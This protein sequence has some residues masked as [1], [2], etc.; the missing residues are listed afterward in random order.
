MHKNR[1]LLA[2]D[3][4]FQKVLYCRGILNVHFLHVI[5]SGMCKFCTY[6]LIGVVAEYATT[7][8]PLQVINLATCAFFATVA[9]FRYVHLFYFLWV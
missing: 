4:N 1:P 2:V 7:T 9:Q 5:H 6:D 3:W 8:N